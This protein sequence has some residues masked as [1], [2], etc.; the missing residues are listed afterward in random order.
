MIHSRVLLACC[1]ALLVAA[2]SDS[3]RIGEWRKAE[4][5]EA[6]F[7]ETEFAGNNQP[8]LPQNR[9]GWQAEQRGAMM[10]T[11]L[12]CYIVSNKQAVCE[13]NNRA[14][15][16]DYISRYYAFK[17]GT[18]NTAQEY[19]KAEIQIVDQFWENLG[20]RRIERA[21]QDHILNGRLNVSDFG[22]SVPAELKDVLAK[23]KGAPDKCAQEVAWRAPEHK[24]QLPTF[25]QRAKEMGKR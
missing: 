15:I 9:I 5:R 17:R 16:V 18:Y 14:Y 2:C 22:W 19:G 20:D 13:K 4:V 21:L 10:A 6:C 25:E 23:H 12:G 11:A 24:H 3:N 1:A 8:R 7:K